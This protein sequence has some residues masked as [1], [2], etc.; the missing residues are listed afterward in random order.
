M[1][2]SPLGYRRMKKSMLPMTPHNCQQRDC[3]YNDDGICDNPRINKGNSDAFCW[4]KNII[5][6]WQWIEPAE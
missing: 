5:T 4:R 3:V 1:K 2:P 6:V